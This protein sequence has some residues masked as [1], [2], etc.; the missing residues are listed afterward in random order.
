MV[1]LKQS[2]LNFLA[3]IDYCS[4]IKIIDKEEDWYPWVALLK[5]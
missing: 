5:K 4:G 1:P 2:D 3:G